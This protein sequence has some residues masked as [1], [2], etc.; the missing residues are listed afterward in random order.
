[1]KEFRVKDKKRANNERRGMKKETNIGE[2]ALKEVIVRSRPEQV[3]CGQ[4]WA[5]M[6]EKPRK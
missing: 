3:L 4:G 6:R 2:N 5:E 1:M